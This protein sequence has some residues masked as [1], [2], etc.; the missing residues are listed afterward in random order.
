MPWRVGCSSTAGGDS[1][2]LVWMIW[3]TAVRS[4]EPSE[5]T[6]RGTDARVGAGWFRTCAGAWR[7]WPGYTRWSLAEQFG[8]DRADE[9]AVEVLV[10][11]ETD[12]GL[13]GAGADRSRIHG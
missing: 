5:E 2:D 11:I 9:D 8:D 3:S 13:V 1:L 6:S 7:G 12:R 4:A 10:G